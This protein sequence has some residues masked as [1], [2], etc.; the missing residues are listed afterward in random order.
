[1]PTSFMK[2]N[3]VPVPKNTKVTCLNDYQPV[4]QCTTEQEDKYI[5]VSSLKLPVEDL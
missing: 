5:R 4:A 2:T 3:I 1:M